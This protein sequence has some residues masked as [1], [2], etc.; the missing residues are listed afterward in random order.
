[1]STHTAR[2]TLLGTTSRHITQTGFA[3]GSRIAE[4][5][6]WSPDPCAHCSAA[7]TWANPCGDY[8][9]C[10]RCRRG[11]ERDGRTHEEADNAA[12]KQLVEQLARAGIE[13]DGRDS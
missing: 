2:L 5:W 9:I 11:F 3:D 4:L 10:T 6:H 8:R 7:A 13:G 1:M 12:I